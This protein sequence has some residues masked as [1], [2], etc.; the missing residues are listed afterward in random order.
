MIRGK[1]RDAVQD[2][3]GRL[4]FDSEWSSNT[5]VDPA[6]PLIA[7]LL[8]NDPALD[9]ILF[10]AVGAGD[11]AWDGTHTAASPATTQLQDEIE[12]HTVPVK[13]IVYLDSNGIPVESPTTW[14]EVSASFT[15]PAEAQTLREFG[16]FGGGASK[17][18]DSGSLIN[19]VI[20]PLLDLAAGTTLTRRL[21]LSLRP[22]DGS[23]WL[24]IPRHWLGDASVTNLIGVGAIQADALADAGIETIGQLAEAEPTAMTVDLPLARRVDVRAKANLA[25]RTV[26]RLSPLSGL[27]N[28]TA[29]QIIVTPTATLAADAGA[30][31]ELVARLR[32]QMNA[33]KSSL[34]NAFLQGVTIG[35][36][37]QPL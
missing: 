30:P 21:R 31:E 28:R 2:T 25:L 34:R 13:S 9:G 10:W 27:L 18:K 1:Y 17:V 32:E 36:L 33:L 19:Y 11:P 15:W 7:G 20:H 5:I 4:V 12:R 23:E 8:K 35:E 3:R 14:I 37:S 29:W 24:D 6:W 22:E 16:L 26:A